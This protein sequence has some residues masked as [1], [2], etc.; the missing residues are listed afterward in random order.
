MKDSTKF[1]C[2]SKPLDKKVKRYILSNKDIIFIQHKPTIAIVFQSWCLSEN[3]LPNDIN[4]TYHIG[5][6]LGAGACGTV[7]F[8]QNRETCQPYALKFSH[9]NNLRTINREISLLRSLHHPCILEL[10]DV[11]LY[12]DSA[13]IFLDFMKGGDLLG[14]IQK[15]KRLS[16]SETKF[17]FYQI[18]SGVQYMH[19]ENVTHRDLKPE[20]ILLATA[21][22]YTL[23][24]I[25]DFGLSKRVQLNTLLETRCGTVYYMAPEV[26]MMNNNYTNKVDIWS[27][28]VILFN[29]LSGQYPFNEYEYLNSNPI[30]LLFGSVWKNISKEAITLVQ[31]C[32]QNNVDRR[33]SIDTVLA[34]NW[35][36]ANDQF[37][38]MARRLM[39]LD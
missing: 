21:D 24:K 13:A 26:R 7:H 32:I 20:N 29:C 31:D 22:V 16:E 25:S 18:C 33:P 23:V 1:G 3:D 14:R 37:V 12:E 34:R 2:K 30:K 8:V 38:E 11:K 17:L 19:R 9:G 15:Q 4:E 6:I 5:R 35:L 27:L 36:S 10:F 28:G 39:N